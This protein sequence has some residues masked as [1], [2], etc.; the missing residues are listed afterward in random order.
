STHMQNKPLPEGEHSGSRMQGAM[1]APAAIAPQLPVHR[2]PTPSPG[3]GDTTPRARV[4]A[5]AQTPH[6][7]VTARNDA[8]LNGTRKTAR[9]TG[10]R[11]T[12]FQTIN[13]W[14]GTLVK[15]H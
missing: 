5:S 10:V 13:K 11:V 6:P 3:R 14:L 9:G 4:R 1:D 15:L 12:V 8:A 7:W 2:T